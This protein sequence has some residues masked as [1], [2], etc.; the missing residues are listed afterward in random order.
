MMPKLP[1]FLTQVSGPSFQQKTDSS[2][3]YDYSGLDDHLKR[4]DAVGAMRD[5]KFAALYS[6]D[7]ASSATARNKIRDLLGQVR[8]YSPNATERSPVL[9]VAP[10]VR[11]S[12]QS[13]GQSSSLD[14][15]SF[16]GNHGDTGTG[17]SVPPYRPQGQGPARPASRPSP[18]QSPGRANLPTR[19]RTLKNGNNPLMTDVLG[20]SGDVSGQA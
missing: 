20:Y 17:S 15:G 18:P 13:S 16:Q 9:Q 12:S 1:P 7:V 11:V 5:A 3:S 14:A 19:R 6:G 10:L 4:Q 2:V 8:A